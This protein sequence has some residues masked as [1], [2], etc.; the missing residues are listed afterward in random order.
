MV[1]DLLKLQDFSNGWKMYD[2]GLRAPCAG[3]Q[4]WQRALAKPFSSSQ[5]PIWRGEISLV[6][7]FFF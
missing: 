6:G 1:H 5:V 3:P 7:H 4:R 2:Y